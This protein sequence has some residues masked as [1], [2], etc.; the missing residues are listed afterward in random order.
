MILL[1]TYCQKVNSSLI[2]YHNAYIVH[3]ILSHHI[4]ILSSHIITR[5]RVLYNKIFRERE[6]MLVFDS[7]V[8]ECQPFYFLACVVLDKPFNPPSLSFCI[9]KM[10]ILIIF[11]FQDYCEHLNRMPSVQQ[12]CYCCCYLEFWRKDQAQ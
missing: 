5:R 12:I 7:F 1:L 10:R 2:L 8:A 4:G 9:F 3:L 11:T 6:I